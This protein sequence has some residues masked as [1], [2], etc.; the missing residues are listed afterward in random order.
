MSMQALEELSGKI[1]ALAGDITVLGSC[2]TEAVQALETQGA[3]PSESLIGQQVATR[4]RL[5]DLREEVLGLARSVELPSLPDPSEIVSVN[6]LRVVFQQ[7]EEKAIR[8]SV[9]ATL[10]RALLLQHADTTDFAPL[11]KCLEQAK[12]LRSGIAELVE[13][14]QSPQSAQSKYA[15][16][17]EALHSGSHPLVALLTLV[18][19]F[20]EIDDEQWESLY[21]TVASS[22]DRALSTAIV[23]QKLHFQPERATR[24]APQPPYAREVHPQDNPSAYPHTIGE[25]DAVRP[26]V[27]LT[28]SQA[29]L[30]DELPIAGPGEVEDTSQSLPPQERA[31]PS[32]PTR[33][34]Q[35]NIQG[36][37]KQHFLGVFP[38]KNATASKHPKKR[39]TEG[40]V[41]TEKRGVLQ[42]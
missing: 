8:L 6:G 33:S 34:V 1:E 41:S 14:A 16:E 12:E 25:T 21:D 28:A 30:R 13:S 2:L 29:L 26:Q 36:A 5:I 31:E 19:P 35:R 22:F 7:A 24:A 4:S 9:L 3:P 39:E 15:S 17:V 11:K 32:Q 27:T 37:A 10:D 40:S 23:R 38:R 20:G 18:E 42:S